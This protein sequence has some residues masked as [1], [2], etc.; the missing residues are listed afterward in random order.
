MEK[1]F[2][3]LKTIKEMTEETIDEQKIKRIFCML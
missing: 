3:N 2:L 1:Y